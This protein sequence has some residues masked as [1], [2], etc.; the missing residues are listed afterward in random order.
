MISVGDGTVTV[1]L[2]ETE[3]A[4]LSSLP[5]GLSAVGTDP[6]DRAGPRIHQSAYPDDPMASAEY[7]VTHGA[8]LEAA[9]AED[10][11][12][13]AATIGMALGG[14]TLSEAETAAWMRVVGE[15]RLVLAA[16]LGIEDSSWERTSP[17]TVVLHY[18]TGLQVQLIDALGRLLDD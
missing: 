1:R 10:R 17:E 5:D 12:V 8:S 11:A 4:L 3:V 18:L 7:E 14:V 15:A 2:G 13:F 9:R 16:R 6:D